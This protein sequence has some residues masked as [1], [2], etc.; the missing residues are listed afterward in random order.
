MQYK[1]IKGSES[2]HCCFEATVVDT[3]KPELDGDGNQIFIEGHPWYE[4]ICETFSIED[5]ELICLA[6]N[7]LNNHSQP[8]GAIT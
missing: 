2:A 4:S 3:T 5:A 1:V 7:E 6:M 8:K